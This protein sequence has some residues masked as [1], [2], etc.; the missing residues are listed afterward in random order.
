MKLNLK[1]FFSILFFSII[2]IILDSNSIYSISEDLEMPVLKDNSLKVELLID[3]IKFPTGMELIGDNKFLII[4]KN[5]GK[6]KLIDQNKKVQTLLDFNVANK[7]E[8]GL[9]GIAFLN[10]TD[11]NVLVHGSKST[12]SNTDY[13]FLFVTETENEDNGE[14]LGNRLY[15]YE[16]TN[17]VL[18]NPVLLLDLPYFPGPSHNGGVIRVG[19]DGNI[20]F[21]MGDL[22]RKN[23]INGNTLAQN[24]ENTFLPDGR[25]GILR[26]TPDGNSV[27]DGF[28]LGTEGFLNKYYAYGIRNSFGIDFDPVTGYLW[29]TENGSHYGDEINIIKPGFNSGWRQ[30]LGLSSLYYNF[31]GKN[32]S[33]DTLITFNKTG[34]Y[35]DP[36]LTWNQTIAPTTIAFIDS[37][38]L[39]DD[40]TN[41][42]LVAGIKN[43]TILHFDLNE[44]RTGLDLQN[45]LT[46]KIVNA[47]SEISNVV[48]GTGFNIVTDI[49][50]DPTDGDLYILS[51]HPKNG[52]IYKISKAD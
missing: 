20:Y 24:I 48:F 16:F 50:I 7:S 44:T 36:V 6:V 10:K 25:G 14:I 5:T 31:S 34:Y 1:L 32:F 8:R 28:Q 21:V 30:V 17:E 52:K 45:D 19:P 15:R 41:D 42:L 29:D 2:F 37:I 47:P 35:T 11:N 18:I 39:G 51:S 12:I 26:I 40:Y 3:N 9:I 23:D 43:G 49:K 13:V 27:K 33:S 22:N 46:D 38:T 4:E